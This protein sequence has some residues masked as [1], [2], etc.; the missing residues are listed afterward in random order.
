[1]IEHWIDL[2]KGDLLVGSDAYDQRMSEIP[3]G[4]EDVRPLAEILLAKEF[5]I[6]TSAIEPYPKARRFT[7]EECRAQG[8]W[9]LNIVRQVDPEMSITNTHLQRSHHL[10]LTANHRTIVTHTGGSIWA[11]REKL[12]A[13]RF[14]PF[15]S[16]S[17]WTVDQ[18]VDNAKLLAQELGRTPQLHDFRK[19]ARE[20]KGPSERAI[21]EFFPGRMRGLSERLG[22]PNIRSW[23]E[24]DYVEWGARFMQ[25]NDGLSPTVVTSQIIAG[26]G[27]GPTHRTTHI[28]FPGGFKAFKTRSE[29]RYELQLAD[30]EDRVSDNDPALKDLATLLSEQDAQLPDRPLE[31]LARYQV[32]RECLAELTPAAVAQLTFATQKKDIV[33]VIRKKDPSISAGRIEVIAVGLDWY[34]EIWPSYPEDQKNLRISKGELTA[35]KRQAALQMRRTRKRL[36]QRSST[37]NDEQQ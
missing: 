12:N 17:D 28:N 24:E 9:V 7:E 4:R 33:N 25:A 32:M 21:I 23:D 20:G 29:E 22:K 15:G 13:P 2:R 37:S 8:A 3:D 16:F 27:L 35:A 19:W 30:Y 14:A 36:K 26:R 11:L 34:D 18:F 1:M 6:D 10:G 31:L 5:D